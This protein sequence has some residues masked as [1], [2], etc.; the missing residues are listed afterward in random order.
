MNYNKLYNNNKALWGEPP[1]PL[2]FLVYNNFKPESFFLD[3]GCGQGRDALFMAKNNFNVT[4]IDS[5][6]VAIDQ[7]KE[8]VTQHNLK[9]IRAINTDVS[10]FEI[11]KNKYDIIQCINA[12][13]FLPKVKTLKLI[14]AIQE[15]IKN[16]GF[17]LISAFTEKDPL[18]NKF[19]DKERYFYR[20]QELLKLF[21]GYKIIYYWENLILDK[22]HPGNVKFIQPHHHGIVKIIAQNLK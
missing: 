1:N 13:S 9:N 5:S 15:K 10:Q 4:A 17:I 3:L 8:Q 2:I 19:T 21:K 16:K 14:V 18:A 6:P 12:L 20:E 22:G 7:L 11:K